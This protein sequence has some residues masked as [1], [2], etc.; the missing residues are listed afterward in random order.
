MKP[1]LMVLP[2]L[3]ALLSACGSQAEPPATA[4]QPSP[5]AL[6]QVVDGIDF[7][8]PEA[9]LLA[10]LVAG[11]K[12]DGETMKRCLLPSQ[13]A[14][15]IGGNGPGLPT[16]RVHR[17]VQREDRSASEVWLSTKTEGSPFVMPHVLVR[18]DARWYVDFSK[19]LDAAMAGPR[20]Q[21]G[22]PPM[23][24]ASNGRTQ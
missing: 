8:S 1:L 18:Q 14:T 23:R 13:R 20:G 15:F 19:S 22:N 11:D 9:V 3:A 6:S 12:A 16:P 24:S 7:G 4:T 21:F 2:L 17:V 10:Y 5:A